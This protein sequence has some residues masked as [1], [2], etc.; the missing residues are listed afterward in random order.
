MGGLLG[1]RSRETLGIKLG[2][3]GLVVLA[4]FQ[5]LFP[6][7]LPGV[8]ALEA[9]EVGEEKRVVGW[10]DMVVVVVVVG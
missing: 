2:Q 4:D 1:R 5:C 3:P 6:D 9:G 7:P 10:W 8:E